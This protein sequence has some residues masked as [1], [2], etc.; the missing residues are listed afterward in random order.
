M[1]TFPLIQE[2]TKGFTGTGIAQLS[3]SAFAIELEVRGMPPRAWDGVV[4]SLE[5]W[6]TPQSQ[7]PPSFARSAVGVAGASLRLS[8]PAVTLPSAAELTLAPQTLAASLPARDVTS[9]LARSESG[10]LGNPRLEPTARRSLRA[11]VMTAHDSFLH[12]GGISRPIPAPTLPSEI[13]GDG[14]EPTFCIVTVDVRSADG[15]PSGYLSARAAGTLRSPRLAPL[16]WY[17]S[18]RAERMRV[19]LRMADGSAMEHT[20]PLSPAPD[21]S[22]A[23]IW[24]ESGEE[25]TGFVA[26]DAADTSLAGDDCERSPGAVVTMKRGNPMVEADATRCSDGELTALCAQPTG[27]GAYTRQY[28]YAF[29][30]GGVTALLHDSAGRHV[31][32]RTI[33]HASGINPEAVA[34]T[35]EGVFI[36]SG[37]G[38][39]IRLHDARSET[40]IRGLT[41]YSRL[42]WHRASNRLWLMPP[43]FLEGKSLT[44]ELTPGIGRRLAS[45]STLVP[46]DPLTVDGSFMTALHTGS[47][48]RVYRFA[49]GRTP[50]APVLPARWV[51]PAVSPGFAGPALLTLD[52]AAARGSAVTVTVSGLD[53]WLADPVCTVT[54]PL[55]EASMA[56]ETDIAS[57]VEIPLLIPCRLAP[58]GGAELRLTV[59]G[60]WSRLA[61]WSLTPLPLP[62]GP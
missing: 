2:G 18:A 11:A 22:D 28:V 54:S 35:P 53:P 7:S 17:P 27:G 47:R 39:L 49:D 10:E 62:E 13:D 36:Q 44:L 19:F 1:P 3:A 30:D 60:R 52:L 55:V 34:P 29:G 42:A 6:V 50:D 58:G 9:T 8:A 25:L 59:A 5:I 56:R 46:G 20:F 23:A 43:L 41:E 31:N 51:S 15:S 33:C 32:A 16:L 40:I 4:R 37:A 48:W 61:A 45:L 26:V 12:L 14:D 57:R 21:G 38:E 24:T